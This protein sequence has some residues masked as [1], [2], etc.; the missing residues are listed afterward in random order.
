MVDRSPSA[1]PLSERSEAFLTAIDERVVIYDGAMGTGVQRRNLT[2]DDFGGED[3]EGCNE[4]LVVTRPDVVTDLH[5]GFLEIGCDVIETDTFGGLAMT[6]AEYGLEDRTHEINLT[7]ARLARQVADEF[8]TPERPRWVAGSMGPGTKFPSLGQVRYDEMRDGF[9]EQAEAL[10]EGGVDILIIE[11]M[12]DLLTIK[13]AMNGCRRAMA[14]AGRQVPL[15]VQ[16]T[17]ELTGRMLPGTEI[18]AALAAIEPLGPDVFGLNCATGPAEMYEHV[19]V[20]SQH[21]SVPISVIPNAGLPSVVDGEMH[22]DLTEEQLADHLAGFVSDLGASIIGGCC[23]TGPEHLQAVIDRCADLTPADRT[24]T[25]LVGAT[26]IYSFVPFEQD[27]SFLIIGERT[28][29][30]GSKKFRE[31]MLSGDEETVDKM[32]KDQIA[33]GAHILDV[34]VDYVG[35]DGTI[36]MDETAKR[37]ATGAA[38]PLVL[39][40]TEPQVMEAGL[41]WLGGRSILNSANLEDGFDEGSR[42]DRVMTL[43][44]EYGAAVICLLIDEEGQARDVEWKM[45]IAHRIHDLAVN[46]YGLTAGDLIFDALTFPLSTG[47]DDLRR[48]GIETIEAIKRIKEEIPGC[49]TTLGLSNISFGLNPALR[50][51]LNSVYLHECL[52]AGLD[53]A[54]IHAGRILPLSKI[55]DERKNATLDLVWDRRGVEGGDGTDPK[56]DPLVKVLDL[57]ADATAIKAEVVDTSDWP[58]DKRLHHRIIDGNREGLST[59]LDEALETMKA[60]EIVNDHLLG[61]MKVVGELFGAG[62]M[63]LPFV[64]QSAETMKAAVAYL[65]PHMERI[66]GEDNSKGRVV[67]ATV[68]GD[69]HDIGKNLVDIILTNNGYEVHNLGIKISI[70]EMIDKAL[71][72]DADAIGMSG[73]LVKSTLIMRDNLEEL[74]RRELSHIPV[75]LGGAALTRSYVERDLREVY[76]GRTFYGKDAFEGMHTLDKLGEMKASGIDDPDFGTV[77]AGLL[78]EGFRQPKEAVDPSSIPARSPEVADDNEVF[79]PPFLG[80]R[81]V[82]GLSVDEIATWINETALF[83]HQWQFRP[84]NGETDPEFKD[85]IRPLFRKQLAEA[86]AAGILNPAVVYGYFPANADGND[87]VIWTDETRTVER[88][89]FSYPRQSEAPFKCIADFYRPVGHDGAKTEADYAAFHIVTMGR[90]VSDIAG[91]LFAADKYQDYLFLHGLG[92]EM[93]EALAEMWH[94]RI[95][96]EWGF[97]DE[98]GDGLLGLFRQ[99]F[100]GGR[101]SWGYPACPDLEDNALVAELLEAGRI[102]VECNEDTAWQ[103]QPE[104]TTSAIICHHPQAKYFVAK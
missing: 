66:E 73:L 47:D 63:Q 48:D 36:D 55:D 24:P 57:F 97:G 70:T 38:A 59:D 30:N 27:L 98:D 25:R 86:K 67:L 92:V 90:T 44:K 56:Y 41:K 20:L 11:T 31:A 26:S 88:A 58:V 34:C 49:F 37:F 96:A 6:L 32:A 51:V 19:R 1:L 43:A 83:R 28:N 53:S 91:E 21:S 2:P 100:R 99:K 80:S 16:V 103:Y 75:L 84:E 50:Q 39:D 15:Q 95:R 18:Q 12:F 7:A 69:V 33:E 71:E 42:F 68:K 77:P 89:R 46:T 93:A 85:R 82:K 60:L 76:D 22:Y 52:E 102:D 13:A 94:G 62:E 78:L 61:G 65:E 17:I 3:L 5:R 29:A 9:E 79:T 40:S 74:N 14:T 23:G 72:I 45:R 4:Y 81:I 104:Q 10:L 64:L 54:I 35:R 8:S 101:Y 87:V